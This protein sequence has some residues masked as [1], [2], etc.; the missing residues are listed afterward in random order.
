MRAYMVRLG[1]VDSYTPLI[2]IL[3]MESSKLNFLSKSKEIKNHR[4]KMKKKFLLLFF[5][6]AAL[7]A[8][9]QPVDLS[10]RLN[11][12]QEYKQVTNSKMTITQVFNGN[13]LTI[14]M[15]INGTMT[16]SVKYS[17]DYGFYMDAK[18]Q[19]LSM[20]MRMP[21]GSMEFSSEK[22]DAN[23][24]FSTILGAMKNK[25]FEV[26]MS[27]T[28]KITEVRNIE[29][30]WSSIINQFDQLSE[31]QKKQ[32]KEQIMKAYGADALKGNIEMVTSI[33]PDKAVKKGEKW[34]IR[35]KLESGMSASMNTEYELVD[36]AE[37][38]ILINGNSIIQTEDKEA[39]I[40]TNGM[41]VKYDLTGSM[42]SVIKVDKSTGWII[43]ASI[44]QE[45]RGDSYL[46]EN[47]QFPK[48]MKIPMTIITDMTIKN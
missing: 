34:A 17:N 12:G 29:A 8:Q 13:N 16:F 21:Q 7:Y 15:N 2:T 35:T 42:K 28:G 33:Y 44:N 30:L 26:V 48:G 1:T 47:P 38:Y 41:P 43:E 32:I 11:N 20:S 40:E 39:Y 6:L 25:S 22:Y 24:I 36:I 23:D 18:F 4:P 46:K 14:D 10:L 31:M 9:A 3:G 45:I 5:T 27:K 19:K 37:T